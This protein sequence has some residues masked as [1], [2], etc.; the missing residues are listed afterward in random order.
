[1]SAIS[2]VI[3]CLGLIQGVFLSLFFFFKKQPLAANRM[4]GWFILLFSL[5]LLEPV[6]EPYRSNLGVALLLSLIGNSSLLYGPLIFGYVTKL[7]AINQPAS[8]HFSAWHCF[9]AALFFGVD[10]LSFV[11]PGISRITNSELVEFLAYELF[12]IQ[13]LTYTILAIRRLGKHIRGQVKIDQS[14]LR[15]LRNLLSILTGIYLFSFL[16]M[17]LIVFFDLPLFGLFTVLKIA[18]VFLIYTISYKAMLEPEVFHLPFK[19]EG[20]DTAAKYKNSGLSQQQAVDHLTKL[21]KCMLKEKPYL[22]SDLTLQGL[23]DRLEINKNQLSQ[24]IN[25]QLGKNF[26]QLVN[27]Y[28]VREAQRMMG[29]P[30]CEHLTLLAIGLESGFSSKTTFNN[31]FKKIT[32]YT[33][34]EW[35]DKVFNAVKEP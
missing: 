9:P 34:S 6:L 4:L 7:T 11:A 17:H 18:I 12:V 1:M 2:V 35:H 31:N 13:I 30:D 14:P 32:G 24:V 22:E 23:A 21:H 10:L 29:D 33:P 15:W 5:G 8:S 3:T 26:Y 20:N 25:E 19:T 27:E 16:T 28:R